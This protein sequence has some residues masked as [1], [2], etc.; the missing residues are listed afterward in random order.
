MHATKRQR[1][2]MAELRVVGSASIADLAQKL[3]VSEETIRRNVKAM[4][5][6]GV[7]A[8][9]HGGVYLPDS[10]REATFNQRMNDN[11]AAKQKIGRAI[12]RHRPGR[13][14][15]LPTS[16]TWLPWAIWLSMT[17]QLSTC[18]LHSRGTSR[19]PIRPLSVPDVAR[20]ST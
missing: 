17:A 16:A 20:C 3:E 19:G 1:D 6:N 11:R 15:P 9:V 2:I 12:A 7:V 14:A 13:P 4:A 10:V 18:R 5:E 8:K